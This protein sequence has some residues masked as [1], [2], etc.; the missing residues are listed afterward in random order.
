MD[1][2]RVDKIKRFLNDKAMSQAV[3]DVVLNAFLR[4][5]GGDVQQLAASRLAIDLLQEGW[6]DLAKY[7]P[8][9]PKEKKEPSADY[10]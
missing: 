4:P 2:T 9:E 5:R 7:R 8:D 10:V 3:Y 1:S 6:R